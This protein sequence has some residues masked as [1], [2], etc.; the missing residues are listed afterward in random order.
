ML[1]A[2]GPF[3]GPAGVGSAIRISLLPLDPPTNWQSVAMKRER[4]RNPGEEIDR[5]SIYL[6][7]S[8]FLF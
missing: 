8:L 6:S 4:E 2:A 1:L 5:L 3:R 7:M